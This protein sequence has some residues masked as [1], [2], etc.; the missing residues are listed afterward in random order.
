MYSMK[1]SVGEVYLGET[2]SG[3]QLNKAAVMHG[4]SNPYKTAVSVP[5][6]NAFTGCPGLSSK[7]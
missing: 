7:V 3:L 6:H 1:K 2:V 5:D 4:S